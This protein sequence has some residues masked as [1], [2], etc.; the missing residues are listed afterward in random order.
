[1]DN[2]DEAMAL[3][4]AIAAA[5]SIAALAVILALLPATGGPRPVASDPGPA[6]A[7]WTDGCVVCQRTAA[8]PACST[9]STTVRSTPSPW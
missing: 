9:R 8:G 5:L 1:M 4:T 2:R 3:V 7:E 6:C